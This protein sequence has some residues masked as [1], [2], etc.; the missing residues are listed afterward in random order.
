LHDA[1]RTAATA[2]IDVGTAPHIV[3]AVLN[4]F[5]G[6]RSGVAG[7]YNRSTYGPEKAAALSRWADALLAI[8]DCTGT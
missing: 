7:I 5:S 1:R 3:E 4:H 6:H 2:M 8:V